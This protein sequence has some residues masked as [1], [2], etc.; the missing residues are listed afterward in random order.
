[1]PSELIWEGETPRCRVQLIRDLRKTETGAY[2]WRGGIPK[3]PTIAKSIV[4]LHDKM[5]RQSYAPTDEQFTSLKNT[6]DPESC[7]L[8]AEAF[9]LKERLNI[10]NLK[11]PENRKKEEI[12]RR[13]CE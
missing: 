6:L 1:M 4:M 2:D 10:A 11:N 13:L 3:N 7:Q 9:Q 12:F 5:L 8:L